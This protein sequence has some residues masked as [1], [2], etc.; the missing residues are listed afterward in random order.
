[1]EKKINV[2]SVNDWKL[3]NSFETK[4][5]FNNKYLDNLKICI[6]PSGQYVAVSNCDKVLRIRDLKNGTC[7]A[8]VFNIKNT[9]YL[10]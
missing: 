5:E 1:M 3:V 10:Y 4:D 6:D 9:I 7:V 2:Y 8:K